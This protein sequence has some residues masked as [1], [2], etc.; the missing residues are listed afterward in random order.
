MNFDFGPF[1]LDINDS[2]LL[3][4]TFNTPPT[5]P[6]GEVAVVEFDIIRQGATPRGHSVLGIQ[7][8]PEPSSSAL[9]AAGILGLLGYAWLQRRRMQLPSARHLKGRGSDI[10]HLLLDDL[11]PVKW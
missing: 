10:Q 7:V 6:L 3:T 2:E 11:L 8:I 5:I 4:A 1:T 9:S